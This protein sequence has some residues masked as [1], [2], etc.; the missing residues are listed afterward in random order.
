MKCCIPIHQLL[1][2]SVA[3][4]LSIS[5][6]PGSV[7]P[8]KL[9]LPSEPSCLS[10]SVDYRFISLYSLYLFL[11]NSQVQ[12][13]QESSPSYQDQDFKLKF[14]RTRFQVQESKEAKKPNHCQPIQ[15]EVK[16][17]TKKRH[18]AHSLQPP[19]CLPPGLSLKPCRHLPYPQS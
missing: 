6:A 7:Q 11:Q 1:K 2:S 13:I 8:L 17:P 5:L 4:I 15:K 19:T 18:I 3:G 12:K 10:R 14:S 9:A 16:E